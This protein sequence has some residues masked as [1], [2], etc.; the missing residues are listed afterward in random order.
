MDLAAK[1]EGIKK[2]QTHLYQLKT[3]KEYSSKLSEIVSLK[4]DSSLFEE[5]ILRVMD[6]IE[7]ADKKLKEEKDKLAA[8]EKKFKDDTDKLD[9][10]AKDIDAQVRQLEDKKATL[11]RDVNKRILDYYEKLLKSRNGIAMAAVSNEN[12]GAC[13]MKVNAQQINEV[14][15]YVDLVFCESCARILYIPEDIQ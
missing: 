2:A 7:A 8:D 9:A 14:K 10:R 11:V 15:M 5:D 1:E 12:C 6:E 4:A 3:N 13:H